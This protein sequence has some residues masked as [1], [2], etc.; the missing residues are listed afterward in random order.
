[1]DGDQ[2]QPLPLP[3]SPP[4]TSSKQPAKKRCT[5]EEK[6][7]DAIFQCISDTRERQ[8]SRDKAVA[9][10]EGADNP[11]VHYGLEIAETMKT[12]SPHQ[13]ALAKLKIRQVL[14]DVQ[15]QTEPYPQSPRTPWILCYKLLILYNN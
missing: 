5:R 13:K 12:F 9:M 10:K 1:M 3:I 7:D 11:D 6:M 14:F 4:H 2:G 8:A 15:F